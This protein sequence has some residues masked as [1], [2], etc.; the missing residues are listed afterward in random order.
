MRYGFSS[1]FVSAVIVYFSV[2]VLLGELLDSNIKV[3]GILA[4]RGNCI[5]PAVLGGIKKVSIPDW[6][7]TAAAIDSRACEFEPIVRDEVSEGRPE[8]LSLTLYTRTSRDDNQ[9]A[10]WP[11]IVTWVRCRRPLVNSIVLG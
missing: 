7:S 4:W 9:L 3:K 5:G 8:K 11:N 1:V 2:G 6:L 10:F